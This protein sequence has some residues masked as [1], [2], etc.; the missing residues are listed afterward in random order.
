MKTKDLLFVVG[1][2]PNFVKIAPICLEL[3]ISPIK[4]CIRIMMNDLE[5]LD[6]NLKVG[7]CMEQLCPI[8]LTGGTH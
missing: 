4:L 2:R 1:T 5:E 8:T 6:M 7:L 3:S